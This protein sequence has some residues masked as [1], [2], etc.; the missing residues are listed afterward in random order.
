MHSDRDG[1]GGHGGGTSVSAER[2]PSAAD[3]QPAG[4]VRVEADEW[5]RRA[6]EVAT[7]F[8]ADGVDGLLLRE[9]LLAFT[10]DDESGSRWVYDGADWWRVAD[11][12]WVG[13]RPIGPLV[14]QPFRVEVLAPDE[15]ERA[16]VEGAEG[17]AALVLQREEVGLDDR[18]VD[19]SE[20]PYQ[21]TNVVPDVGLDAWHVPDPLGAPSA[22]LDPGL[23]VMVLSWEV[24]GW[25]QIRC[26]NGWEAWVDA[27]LL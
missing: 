14:P 5:E 3:L 16:L 18:P 12:A 27:R 19:P 24:S 6:L 8:A 22:H 20:E 25:A 26:S 21:P 9:A 15:R 1:E 2:V 17:S 11:G 23:D 7:N 10:F 4:S 13:G